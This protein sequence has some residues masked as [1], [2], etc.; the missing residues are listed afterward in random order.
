MNSYRAE[1]L[2]LKSQ[3]LNEADKLLTLFSLEDGKIRAVARGARRS[4][5]RLLAPS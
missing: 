3:D 2:V 4:R 5:N 1:A